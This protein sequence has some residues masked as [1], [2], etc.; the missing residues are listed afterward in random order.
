M[1]QKT[2]GII[3]PDAT[4]RNLVGQIIADLQAT[5]L[6]LVGLKMIRLDRKTAEEFYK[7]HSDKHFFN[8]LV[9]FMTSEDI[10]VF[11]L[12]GENAVLAYRDIMG[13]TDPVEAKEGTLRKK[14][15]IRKAENS[16]HGSDSIESAERELK[17]FN[18]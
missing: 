18:L 4:K 7:E 8:E 14:Y 3:K 2:F 13:S 15:A 10:V 17:I 16:V 5:D 9:D 6:K 12:E 11:A 1:I